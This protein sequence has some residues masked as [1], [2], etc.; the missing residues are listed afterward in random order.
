[1]AKKDRSKENIQ[2]MGLEA[3]GDFFEIDI[4][5][6]E[7][8]LIELLHKKACIAMRFEREMNLTHRAVELNYLRVFKMVSKDKKEL[9][10]LIKKSL[11]QYLK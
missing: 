9:Q 7:P 11:P 5:S 3:I 8:K 10:K 6:I 1:M 2:K 4:Q